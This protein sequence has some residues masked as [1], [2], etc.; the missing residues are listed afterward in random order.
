M[1]KVGE[2]YVEISGKTGSLEA[3]LKRIRQE[4]AKLDKELGKSAKSADDYA[5]ELMDV[6]KAVRQLAKD[7][8]PLMSAAIRYLDQLEKIEKAERAGVFTK[9]QTRKFI[10]AATRE[11][12]MATKGQSKMGKMAAFARTHIVALGVAAAAAA[13]TGFA[14]MVKNSFDMAKNLQDLA[15]KLGVGVETL[16]RW[17]YVAS[18][19]G[20]DASEFETALENLNRS[21]GR[22]AGGAKRETELFKLLGVS[23]KDAEGK[24]RS[25]ET[26]LPDIADALQRVT[27]KNQRAAVAQVLFGNA[28]ADILPA[29]EGGSDRINALSDAADR[30]GI[31]MSAEQI[32]KLDDAA[33]KAEAL[34]QVLAAK[35]AKTVADN[36]DSIMVFTDAL[37]DLA[38]T[39]LR[40]IGVLGDLA[41]S[42]LGRRI[43]ASLSNALPMMREIKLILDGIDAISGKGQPSGGQPVISMNMDELRKATTARDEASAN[44]IDASNFLANNTK[45]GDTDRAARRA[46]RDALQFQNEIATMQSAI[47]REAMRYAGTAEEQ[48]TLSEA[49]LGIERQRFENGLKARIAGKQ[50]TNAQAGELRAMFDKQE[51][52]KLETIQ[53]EKR[54]RL[55]QEGLALSGARLASE[56]EIASLD[57]SLATTRKEQK[58]IA[59]GLLDLSYRQQRAELEAVLQ[60]ETAT[61]I[62]KRIAH[63]RLMTL[64]IT[65]RL[66]KDLIDRDFQSP[67]DA[68]LDRITMAEGEVT[69]TLERVRAQRLED[70]IARSGQMADDISEAFANVGR[71]ILD[72]RN[73]LQILRSLLLD[74]TQIFNEE[75]LIRPL[76]EFARQNIGGPLA[77]Q[78]TGAPAGPEG[79]WIKQL[80][81]ESLKASFA[82]DQMAL[83]ATRAMQAF[84]VQAASGGGGGGLLGALVKG[85]S[86]SFSPSASLMDNVGATIAANPEIFHDGGIVGKGGRPDRVRRRGLGPREHMIIAEEGERIIDRQNSQK[87][88]GMLQDIA[89]GAMPQMGVGNLISRVQQ[90]TFVG[91]TINAGGIHIHGANDERTARRSGKQAANE[92]NRRIAIA[93]KK[94]YGWND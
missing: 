43:G 70:R 94:G 48:A 16:Q 41:N 54:Q 55:I 37:S 89:E 61:E 20:V 3:D 35:I 42:D 15:G 90:R 27:D 28:A 88:D 29:L 83:A 9:D 46:A 53:I 5:E 12:E 45:T 87:F 73:P 34:K 6:D 57:S 52:A 77:E 14:L 68:L 72:L 65:E 56:E 50:I 76:Q 69:E 59:L 80:G 40:V 44:P 38:E 63:E 18:Q 22:A 26:V 60:S 19:S 39:T 13:G 67:V 30:L 17:N 31:V 25:L 36:A 24:A 51:S 21:M 93:A 49:L 78:A 92:I 71:D 91:P 23:L 66:N 75:V 84:S 33:K 2:V 85:V 62:E 74:M 79:L 1:T 10:G 47:L 4:S 58:E 32:N 11:Y 64:G 81:T 82:I 86:A 8:D 7:Y